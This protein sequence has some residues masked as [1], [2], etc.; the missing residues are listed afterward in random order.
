MG[1]RDRTLAACGAGPGG[2]AIPGHFLGFPTMASFRSPAAQCQPDS[3]MHSAS[4]TVGD[5]PLSTDPVHAKTRK[6]SAVRNETTQRL[7]GHSR[8]LPPCCPPAPPGCV[9]FQRLPFLSS[10]G[11]SFLFNEA[12]LKLTEV[13]SKYKPWSLLNALRYQSQVW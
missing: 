10:L 1:G 4:L 7:H 2:V 11:L 13:S 3:G 6:S 9:A 5:A 8:L 12:P